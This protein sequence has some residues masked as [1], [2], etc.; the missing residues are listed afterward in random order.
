LARFGELTLQSDDLDQI[1]TEACRIV[2]AALGNDLAK[3]VALQPDGHT[4]LVVAGVGWKPGVVGQ[5]TIEVSDDTSE[6]VALKTGEAMISPDIALET[7]FRYPPFLTDN[8]V[9][10]VSNVVIN[11]RRRQSAVR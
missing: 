3:V 7:R 4:L 2:G 5:A 11:R 9:K 6:G 1:L 8:S 10:A